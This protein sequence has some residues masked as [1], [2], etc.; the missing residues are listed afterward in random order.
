MWIFCLKQLED[1]EADGQT[2]E[3]KVLMNVL[4]VFFFV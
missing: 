4:L 3:N 1:Q 2:E